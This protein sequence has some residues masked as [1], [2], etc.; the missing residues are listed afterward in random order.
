VANSL[1][2]AWRCTHPDF[3]LSESQIGLS[4]DYAGRIE[5][6]DENASV[7]QSILFLLTTMPGERVM[8]PE[9]GCD[10]QHLLFSSNEAT[11]HG[12]VIYYIRKAITRWEPRVKIMQLDAYSDK[13]RAERMNILL[14]YKVKR[15]AFKD[16]LMIP[17]DLND[18]A[19]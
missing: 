19:P 9:Y 15:T 14:K 5:M 3:I 6:V 7:R 18:E 13:E 8:R 4:L 10:L 16:T 12:M 2:R 17:F 11:T 1:Y